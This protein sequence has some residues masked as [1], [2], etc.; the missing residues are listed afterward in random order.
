MLMYSG[1]ALGDDDNDSLLKNSIFEPSVVT[2][3][4]K[5]TSYN[6]K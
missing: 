6:G 5:H 3:E 4:H 1:K 2:K